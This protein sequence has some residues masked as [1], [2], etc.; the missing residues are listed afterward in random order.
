MW[1]LTGLGGNFTTKDEMMQSVELILQIAVQRLQESKD[2]A[3]AMSIAMKDLA[4]DILAAS[5]SSS[6]VRD[7]LLL[8]SLLRLY[9]LC[10][11][12]GIFD[13]RGKLIQFKTHP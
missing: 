3:E 10:I 11:A 7:S 1:T 9:A 8:S 6:Q 2:E 4:R 5:D 13:E 12:A